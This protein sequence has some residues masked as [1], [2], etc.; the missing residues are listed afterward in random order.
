MTRPP[1]GRQCS[2]SRTRGPSKY[3]PEC[4]LRLKQDQQ[5]YEKW[6]ETMRQVNR[7]SRLRKK[8]RQL[9]QSQWSDKCDI[10][11][12]QKQKGALS[13]ESA[14]SG[15]NIYAYIYIVVRLQSNGCARIVSH[16]TDMVGLEESR[17]RRSE[18]EKTEDLIT[19]LTGHS[20]SPR[21][22]PPTRS[23]PS[24]RWLEAT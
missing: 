1:L 3:K 12:R 24:E 2:S 8:M 15:L 22:C 14:C 4:W 20:L 10:C 17:R 16:Y 6:K 19:P 11:R 23:A 5:R 9:E 21:S 13:N 7:K 18:R